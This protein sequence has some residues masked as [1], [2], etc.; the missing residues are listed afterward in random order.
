MFFLTVIP[1]ITKIMYVYGINIS[2]ID[3]TPCN[4]SYLTAY[5]SNRLL[6]SCE[7][8]SHIS[9]GLQIGHLSNFTNIKYQ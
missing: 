8:L 9:D 4:T 6:I 7:G 1:I 2:F 5:H 3:K